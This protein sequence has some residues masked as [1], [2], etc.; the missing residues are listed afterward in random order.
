MKIVRFFGD[1]AHPENNIK[2]IDFLKSKYAFVVD[3]RTVNEKDVVD[4]GRKLVGTQA[5]VLLEIE[6]GPTT[7]DLEAHIFCIADAMASVQ[8]RDVQLALNK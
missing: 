4:S 5:G 3:F 1:V 2:E 7:K 8:G 6:K